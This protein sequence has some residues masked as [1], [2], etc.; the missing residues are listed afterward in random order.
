MTPEQ[1]F[2]R[3]N[4][5]SGVADVSIFSSKVHATSAAL[6]EIPGN[7]LCPTSSRMHPSA[8]QYEAY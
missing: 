3:H 7:I 1:Q 5:S 8:V 6:L 2:V 4:D